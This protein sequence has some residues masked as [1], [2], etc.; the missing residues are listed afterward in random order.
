MYKDIILIGPMGVGKTTTGL[1][2]SQKLQ[3][4]SIC[5]DDISLYYYYKQGYSVATANQLMQERGP[6][7]MYAYMKPLDAN[8]VIQM[9]NDF[10]QCVFDLGAGQ[11]VYED[12]A[13]FEQIQQAL[14]P[15]ENV[16]LLIPASD[17]AESLAYLLNRAGEMG[18]TP[19]DEQVAL[20]KHFIEHPSNWKLAKHVIFIKD[21]NPETICDEVLAVTRLGNYESI[22]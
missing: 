22:S 16:V 19:T 5:L 6:V 14:G 17:H 15:Y 4:Q 10:N 2:M 11:S 21:K 3:V 20:L 8:S 18:I 13:L 7:G 12:E 9:L 1:L